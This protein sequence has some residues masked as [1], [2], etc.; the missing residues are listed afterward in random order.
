MNP[1]MQNDASNMC[2]GGNPPLNNAASFAARDV[3]YQRVERIQTCKS[4]SESINA[5][6]WSRNLEIRTFIWGM[7]GACRLFVNVEE[8]CFENKGFYEVS[9]KMV[10]GQNE[11]KIPTHGRPLKSLKQWLL[12]LDQLMTAQSTKKENVICGIRAC[13]L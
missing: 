10:D 13:G 9:M 4:E 12:K 1:T 5:L 6:G 7:G 8:T 3:D 11:T 2:C